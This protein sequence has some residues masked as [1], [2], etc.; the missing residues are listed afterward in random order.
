[1]PHNMGHKTV[2]DVTSHPLVLPTLACSPRHLSPQSASACC[3]W[4]LLVL[5]ST[6]RCWLLHCRQQKLRP[7]QPTTGYL[8][9]YKC[10]WE[11]TLGNELT[12]LTP[13]PP[14]T[15]FSDQICWNREKEKPKTKKMMGKNENWPQKKWRWFFVRQHLS[16][17]TNSFPFRFISL[18]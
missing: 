12:K 7:Y 10:T 1:M 16:A 8:W 11:W 6:F 5:P 18:T 3:C 13:Q 14:P 9:W 17:K 4:T 15:A 2:S